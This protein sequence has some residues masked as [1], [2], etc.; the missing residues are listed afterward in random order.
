MKKNNHIS[1][2]PENPIKSHIEYMAIETEAKRDKKL[3]RQTWER[4]TSET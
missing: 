2:I 1:G 3:H 4:Y